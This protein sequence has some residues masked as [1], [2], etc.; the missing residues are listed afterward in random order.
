YVRSAAHGLPNPSQFLPGSGPQSPFRTPIVCYLIQVS[1]K[2]SAASPRRTK[3]DEPV[4]DSCHGHTRHPALS[5][6]QAA[7]ESRA[8]GAFRRRAPDPDRRHVR[9]HVRGARNRPRHD[10]GRRA[11]AGA[12]RRRLGGEERALGADQPRDRRKGRRRRH[13]GGLP[14]GARLFRRGGAREPHPCPLP[15]PPRRAARGKLRRP[16]RGVR[17]ARDRSPRRQAV[18]RLPVRS[19]AA[20]HPQAPRERTP[21]ARPR[22]RPVG[23]LRM[24]ERDSGAPRLVFAGT[25]AFA[26][27]SL[28]ALVA[29]GMRP[30]LVPTQPARPAGRGRRLTPSPVKRV[31]EEHGTPVSQPATLINSAVVEEL[32]A[33]EPDAIVVVAYGLLLPP[34]VLSLPRAGCLNVHA[35]LLPRWRGAAPV[36][37]AILAGDEQTGVSLMRMDEGL[38]TG[39]VYARVPVAIGEHET[40]GEL[41]AR[42]AELGGQ[43][44]VSKLP[45]VLAGRLVAEPQPA[46]GVT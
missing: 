27:P 9:D 19:Q 46:T 34:D 37:A 8:G 23:P 35:S 33:L 12:G 2:F 39:P 44:L 32:A 41:K 29:H 24:R 14:L 16:A 18:R 5:R 45:D 26:V 15:R 10:P 25:P 20:A 4:F 7:H 30:L 3:V 31:A 13:G 40:A 21:P 28:R 22:R 43:L 42:L 1:Q 6:S 38:D 17:A 11:P 36:E